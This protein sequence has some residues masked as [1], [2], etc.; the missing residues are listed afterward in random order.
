M[1]SR[2]AALIPI[3]ASH[4]CLKTSSLQWEASPPPS[5][6]CSFSF[7]NPHPPSLLHSLLPS[8]HHLVK[9]SPCPPLGTKAR[10]LSALLTLWP[11][12][13]SL[14]IPRLPPLPSQPSSHTTTMSSSSITSSLFF[15]AG[16]AFL[17]FSPPPRQRNVRFVVCSP[18]GT[19]R[20]LG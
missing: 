8:L 13:T 3:V 14:F 20:V 10:V 17:F 9:S 15:S 1:H 18:S 4:I 12:H 11:I 2:E 5:C 16:C 6:P 7:L 19:V